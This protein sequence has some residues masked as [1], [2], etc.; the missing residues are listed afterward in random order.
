MLTNFVQSM[1]KLCANCLHTQ[2]H[3]HIQFT[4]QVYT[5][6]VYCTSVQKKLVYYTGVYNTGF[7]YKCT[8]NQFTEQ[9]YTKPDIRILAILGLLLRS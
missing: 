9:V 3:R 1:C 2:T 5:K 8:Q 7:L 6:Q 4:A